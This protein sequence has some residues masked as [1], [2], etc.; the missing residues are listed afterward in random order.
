MK[1]N[2]KSK[3]IVIALG[4]NALIF[5]KSKKAYSDQKKNAEKTAKKIAEIAK[6][7]HRIIITHGNGPQ[8]GN[9]LLQ[10]ERAKNKIA[11]MPLS[12]CGAQSQGQIGTILAIAL[13]NEFQK[14]NIKTLAIALVSHVLVDAKDSAFSTPTKPIGP[15]RKLVASPLP[16]KILEID[17]IKSIL[18]KGLIPIV[19][20]GGGIPIIKDKGKLQ[21]IDA[22]IDKD[23]ASQILANEL[24]ADELIILTKIKKV[25]VNFKKPNQKWLDKLN[26]KQAKKY[27]QENQFAEG[28]MKPKIQAAIKF[29]EKGEKNKKVIIGN[30]TLKNETCTVITK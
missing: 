30:L 5:A 20:G 12:V 29:L 22:V 15:L 27:L 9:I 19:V 24:N 21:L 14:Q 10:Q 18:E 26:I 1:K 17:A 16:Q 13:N 7:K 3:T 23:F 2:S 11:P 8:V 6:K 28:S 4:G 25:A